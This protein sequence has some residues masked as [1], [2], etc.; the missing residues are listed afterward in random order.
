MRNNWRFDFLNR[1]VENSFFLKDDG[2]IFLISHPPFSIHYLKFSNL[3]KFYLIFGFCDAKNA[4]E[5]VLKNYISYR[6]GIPGLP[7]RF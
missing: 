6:E 5:R 2:S 4:R 3:K 1:L 7:R